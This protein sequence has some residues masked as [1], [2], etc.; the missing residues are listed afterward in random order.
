MAR[1]YADEDFD[2]PVVVEL[3]SLGHDVLTVPEAGNS[4]DE[5]SEVLDYAI[6]NGR[7][8]V[9]HNRADFI[10]LHKQTASHHGIVVCTRD[11]NWSALAIRI[12]QAI[13]AHTSLDDLLIRINRPA[14]P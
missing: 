12:H 2:Y 13:G 1:L 11:E 3:R 9:T 6:S 10:R 7:S 14:K 4:G 5:D 8:V